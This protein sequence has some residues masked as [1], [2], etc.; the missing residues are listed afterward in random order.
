MIH[1]PNEREMAARELLLKRDLGGADF[2]SLRTLGE[3]KKIPYR[4]TLK[5][6]M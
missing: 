1:A 2:V 5:I 6:N 4:Y 3:Y